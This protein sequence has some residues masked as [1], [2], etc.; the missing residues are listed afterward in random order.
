MCCNVN[1]SGHFERFVYNP[2]STYDFF[3]TKRGFF[4]GKNAL[5][6]EK[7]YAQIRETIKCFKHYSAHKLEFVCSVSLKTFQELRSILRVMKKVRVSEKQENVH[8]VIKAGNILIILSF[9][10]RKR[11]SF[12]V[13]YILT[14]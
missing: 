3:L 7:H 12:T 14:A 4:R 6:G 13:K 1:K 8:F 11:T 10:N 2:F 9:Q 5:F